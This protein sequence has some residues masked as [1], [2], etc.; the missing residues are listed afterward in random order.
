MSYYYLLNG[1]KTLG[2]DGRS[3]RTGKAR[4]GACGGSLGT[5]GSTIHGNV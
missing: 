5:N 4:N 3:K 2:Q 1:D